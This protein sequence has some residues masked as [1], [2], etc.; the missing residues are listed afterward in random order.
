MMIKNNLSKIVIVGVLFIAFLAQPAQAYAYWRGGWGWG[1]GWPVV[2]AVALGATA[3]TLWIAGHQYYYNDGLYYNYTPQGYVVVTPPQ[4]L[5]TQT[6]DSDN[7]ITVNIPNDKG[8]Y[9]TVV[10]KRSGKGFVGPQG[11]FYPDFPKVSQLK[12]MYGK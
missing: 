6:Q 3:T 1:W 5:V 9:T 7:M 10:I 2:G 12:L 8:G 11:E 4:A